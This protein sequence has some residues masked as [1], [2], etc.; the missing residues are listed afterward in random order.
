VTPFCDSVFQL[1]ETIADN[2]FAFKPIRIIVK[3]SGTHERPGGWSRRTLAVKG[4]NT[5]L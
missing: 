5:C 3:A 2:V 1:I 4:I